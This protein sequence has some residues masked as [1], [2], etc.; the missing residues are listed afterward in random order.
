MRMMPSGAAACRP[1][2]MM[3]ATSRSSATAWSR[4][5]TADRSWR[6][7]RISST[8]PYSWRSRSILRSR[9]DPRASGVRAPRARC[10]MSSICT[11]ERPP[12]SAPSCSGGQLPGDLRP[13]PLQLAG[14]LARGPRGPG[15]APPR[16]PRP[17]RPRRPRTRRRP[18]PA[19]SG[20]RRAA[21]RRWPG[22]EAQRASVVM[23][24]R[25]DAAA[26]RRAPG[27]AR[28][29]SR[30]PP[31]RARSGRWTAARRAGSAP[32]PGPT[33]SGPALR[34]SALRNAFSRAASGNDRPPRDVVGHD[35]RAARR[36]AGAG[37]RERPT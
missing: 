22:S 20:R 36:P 12:V 10:T 26:V 33:G 28:S 27:C 19:R 21:A 31:S 14:E 5:P 15:G 7:C 13:A 30:S 3:S 29:R 8:S 4:P 17:T 37:R 25:S 24:W 1:R 9:I 18:R 34:P 35:H 16:P 11:S 6:G 23:F 2:R 32:A